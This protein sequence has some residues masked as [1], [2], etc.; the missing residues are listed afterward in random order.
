MALLLGG[1]IAGGHTIFRMSLRSSTNSLQWPHMLCSALVV[2]GERSRVLTDEKVANFARLF[3][4]GSWIV[5]P[6]AGHHVQ[7]D[8]P[9]GLSAAIRS[10]LSR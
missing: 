3:R 5:V 4:D 1:T 9:K 10:F 7:E 8:N 6:G 2:R